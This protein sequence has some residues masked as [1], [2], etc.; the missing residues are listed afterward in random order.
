[1]KQI[2][3]LSQV[4]PYPVDA[5]PKMRSYYVLRHLTQKHKVTL[6]TFV[7]DSD[8]PED[9][10]HL[11]ELCHA[12]HTVPMQRNRLRDAGFLLQSL[13]TQ[14]PFLIVRD[15]VPAMA[16]KIRQLASAQTFDAVHVDQLWM[17]Q[18]ALIAKKYAS[19]PPKLILDQH[20]AVYLIPKRLA[21]GETN[22]LKQKILNR[23]SRL[24]A[25]YE[26]DICRRFDHVVWVTREDYQAV[27]RVS[28]NG[29]TPATIIP[30]CA[31]PAQVK[32]VEPALNHQ[33]ITFLG[34]LHWPPNAQGV[35]WFAKEVLPLVRQKMPGATLTV[36]G[37]N[38]PPELAGEGVEITGYVPDLTPYLAETAVFVVPLH[39]GGGMRVKI[40]DAW[41]W[42]L[43][44]VSTTIGAEGMDVRHQDNILIADTA[45]TFARAVLSLLNNTELARQIGQSG[46]QTIMQSYNWQTVYTAWDEVY[47]QV[48]N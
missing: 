7:R 29:Q 38:P 18:Y 13:F 36:I 43:P 25:R 5:G 37:K 39:A 10:A 42:G 16:A 20:N 45:T 14:S 12:V 48:S 2:L 30:I 34:G 26:I 33:R 21:D 15:H 32:P 17:A 40:L 19:S 47:R 35:V 4:L 41:S 24:L 9:I 44:V 28:K 3:F 6:L 11:S 22:P 23:E 27:T 46:R 1:M 31:D 8:R